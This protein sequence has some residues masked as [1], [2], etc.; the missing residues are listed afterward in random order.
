MLY[1]IAF[2]LW[3]NISLDF[4][5][6][7]LKKVVSIARFDEQ[8]QNIHLI[9]AF[10]RVVDKISDARL[11]LYG[12]GDKEN[13][14]REFISKLNLEENVIIKGFTNNVTEVLSTAAFKIM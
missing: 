1:T 13:E 3:K 9:K 5:A 4:K 12:F 10:K 2:I 11:E 8:K 7:D 6:R 14:M